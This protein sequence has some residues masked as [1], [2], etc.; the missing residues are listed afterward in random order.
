MTHG[1]KRKPAVYFLA[2]ALGA[3]VLSAGCAKRSV[4][5]VNGE[6]ITRDEFLQ[7]TISFTGG[8]QANVAAGLQILDSM[9]NSRLLLQEAER[10]GVMPTDAEVEQR[11]SLIRT[12]LQSQAVNLQ[13]QLQQAGL[14][15]EALRHDMRVALAQEK[16]LTKGLTVTDQEVEKFY[17]DNKG[18]PPFSTPAQVQ[19]SHMTLPTQQAATE[20]RTD[21][22]S[23]S[24][25][26]VAVSRSIDIFKDAGG[27]VG[28]PLTRD[29]I[30]P[31]GPIAPA[32]LTKAFTMKQG[33][34]S[35]PIRVGN[36]WVIVKVEQ[37]TPAKTQSLEEVKDAIRQ[38]L[39]R[40]KSQQSGRMATVQSTLSEL[41]QQADIAVFIEPYKQAEIF[42]PQPVPGVP[43]VPGG[44]P[45]A[46]TAPP[47]A[48][49]STPPAAG[50]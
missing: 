8:A 34:V 25:N 33:E 21:L 36:Q 5:T 27:Q 9:I 23:A 31:G 41:R 20:A 4:A 32:V 37:S 47:P 42:R 26:L 12:E 46:G 40:Q 44:A 14:T 45:P 39:L 2:A 13:E 10:Q 29:D 19:I 1:A 24:F 11:M 3:L 48:P 6:S 30:R 38:G 7:R 49:P 35:D 22:K 16:L 18:Q 50:P 43:A 15:E 17:N 28:Q